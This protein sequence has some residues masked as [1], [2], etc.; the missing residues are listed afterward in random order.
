MDACFWLQS[1]CTSPKFS[2]FSHL[3]CIRVWTATTT[4]MSDDGSGGGGGGG[5]R[6]F[7]LTVAWWKQRARA[8]ERAR[9]HSSRFAFICLVQLACCEL[10]L[11]LFDTTSTIQISNSTNTRARQL[12]KKYFVCCN[13]FFC[14]AR[15]Q[16]RSLCKC[17]YYRCCCFLTTTTKKTNVLENMLHTAAIVALFRK[18]NETRISSAAGCRRAQRRASLHRCIDRR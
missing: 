10:A 3:C 4:K 15:S 6:G 12:N 13:S 16:Q 18:I 9:A 1:N 2:S 8:P 11:F 17:V 5:D 14:F 7:M